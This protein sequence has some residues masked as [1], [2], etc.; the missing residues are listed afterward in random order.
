MTPT[1]SGTIP[2]LAPDPEAS[3]TPG[4][5]PAVTVLVTSLLPYLCPFEKICPDR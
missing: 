4:L 2:L 5:R 3:T 1:P